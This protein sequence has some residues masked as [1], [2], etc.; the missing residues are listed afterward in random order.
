MG[1]F[2]LTSKKASVTLIF[3]VISV[4]VVSSGVII[5]NEIRKSDNENNIGTE[6]ILLDTEQDTS[7]DV[8][9]LGN[10]IKF[11]FDEI[12]KKSSSKKSSGGGSGGSASSAPVITGNVVDVP[13]LNEIVDNQNETNYTEGVNETE[14]DDFMNLSSEILNRNGTSYIMRDGKEYVLSTSS[15]TYY[16]KFDPSL[17]SNVC[18][19]EEIDIIVKGRARFYPDYGDLY[20][21]ARNGYAYVTWCIDLM[22]YDGIFPDDLV[23]WDCGSSKSYD[24]ESFYF[25]GDFLSVDLSDAI[26]PDP[27]ASG[28]FYVKIYDFGN[29]VG[30]M[31]TSSYS[32][33]GYVNGECDCLS[34]VCCDLSSRPYEFKPYLSQP[35]GYID[36]YYCSGINSPTGT[37]SVIKRDY[38]CTG[39]S[40]SYTWGTFNYDTCGI[41]EYCTA[42]DSTCNYYGTS[43]VCGTKD[44][45]YLDTTCRNYHDVGKY[46]NGAGSCSF[47]MACIDYT[48]K[49][50]HTSC[51]TNNE[52]DG[53][54]TCITCTSHSYTKCAYNDIYWYDACDNREEKKQECGNDGCSDWYRDT[55]HGDDA[56]ETQLCYNKGCTTTTSFG[57]HCYSNSYENER[58]VET[59]QYGCI[60]GNCKSNPNI[61]CSSNIDCGVND[62]SG[63]PWCSNNDVYQWYREYTCNNP[64]TEQSF[65]SDESNIIMKEDCREDSHSDNYCY[66]ND[67]YQN[68]TDRG[69]S[70]GACFE[71]TTTQKVQECGAEGCLDGECVYVEC[72][73]DSECGVNDYVGDSSCQEDNVWQ[74]YITYTCNNAGTGDSYC[75]NSTALELKEDCGSD[76][77]E[78]WQDDYCEDGDVYH[79]KICHNKGCSIGVCFD[80]EYIEE[81]KVQECGVSGYTGDNYCHNDN[82]YRDY[83]TRD[84]S[85]SDCISSTSKKKI[86]DCEHGCISGRCKIEICN[87]GACYYV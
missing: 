40:A 79:D 4:L 56:Y 20:D 71:N 23:D 52:C 39:L 16:I 54:G 33:Y 29:K 72:Y 34:G 18:E 12:D 2:F 38:Y 49:P 6:L 35:T 19:N 80:N 84:C 77:C 14:I 73:N 69:C 85:D 3:L 27:G 87:Y 46:C 31:S 10:E 45:D 47:A 70:D 43:T 36:S 8:N 32:V 86:E 83:I 25:E 64:G 48:N 61:I 81:E 65:C 75:S 68:F 28:E 51:G 44:C 50:K 55:C 1:S 76:Y 37:S 53:S 62:L 66:D 9:S 22:E 78:D 30:E 41:C 82:V 21:C 58:F 59:C 60:N 42:G 74:N 26:I 15:S 57:V 11:T 5:T 63:S 7:Q 13:V 67:V 17:P 24:C